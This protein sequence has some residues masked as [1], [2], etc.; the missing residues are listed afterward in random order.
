MENKNI[1]SNENQ[2]ENINLI[3]NSTEKSN[4]NSIKIYLC[5]NGAD[6]THFFSLKIEDYKQKTIR[7]K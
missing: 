4:K 3:R 5:L 1:S 6:K 7:N 2:T